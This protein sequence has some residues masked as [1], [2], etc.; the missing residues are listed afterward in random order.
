M[1][2]LQLELDCDQGYFPIQDEI[3]PGESGQGYVLRMAA[4]NGLGGIAC[5]K[6]M[7][8][9]SRFQTL[10][11]R[12]APQLAL[13][14]GAS[15]QRLA[16]AMESVPGGRRVEGSTY[17][18]HILGRSYF[19]NRSHPRVC[20]DCVRELGYCRAAWDFALSVA[21]ARHQR[22]LIDRCPAC[23]SSLKWTRP[24]LCLCDCA[25]PW[26]SLDFCAP[27]TD[28]ELLV[29]QIIDRRMDDRVHVEK[30]ISLCHQEIRSEMRALWL[31]MEGLSMDGV[32]RLLFAFATAACYETDALAERRQRAVMSKARQTIS[33]GIAMGIKLTQQ[34]PIC[35][36]TSPSVLINLLKECG[37]KSLATAFDI[38]I[39][40]SLLGTFSLRKG[41]VA[42][43]GSRGASMSQLVLF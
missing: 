18:G 29:A 11:A 5:V 37:A 22:L 6:R 16:Y 34:K 2:R 8:G 4:G 30:S 42:V 19:V 28:S 17:M 12:D 39:A 24:N 43:S 35:L 38:S 14:F 9:C 15:V 3:F 27:A 20:P 31:I 41:H 32:C 7:L 1:S 25:H 26:S 36:R 23:S 10:Y 40:Q 21:C 33:M 13:W